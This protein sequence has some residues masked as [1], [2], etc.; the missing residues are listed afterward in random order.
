LIRDHIRLAMVVGREGRIIE[1]TPEG[2]SQCL[3]TA[4][5]IAHK[6][7]ITNDDKKAYEENDYLFSLIV[8][9]ETL[10]LCASDSRFKQR[11]AF[12]FLNALK[13]DYFESEESLT[14]SEEIEE[15]KNQMIEQLEYYSSP[16]SDKIEN[17]Q[18]KADEVKEVALENLDK[19]FRRGDN[20]DS[21]MDQ[22]GV[23]EERGKHFNKVSGK[24][25]W[26][27]YRKHILWTIVCVACCLLLL[28][29]VLGIIIAIVWIAVDKSK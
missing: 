7:P 6:V 29:L 16:G 9:E 18:V 19:L 12:Q 20:L 17:L 23:L 28:L 22:A 27:E 8:E 3:K 14:T 10:F 2:E 21:T 5:I 11:K 26:M 1:I 4:R 24:Q 25:K 15:F 13:S